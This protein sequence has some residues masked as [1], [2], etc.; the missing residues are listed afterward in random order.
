ME[1]NKINPFIHKEK[2]EDAKYDLTCLLRN[3]SEI[4]HI[5]LVIE[6]Y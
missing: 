5:K 6:N 3:Y 4:D 1:T 2:K